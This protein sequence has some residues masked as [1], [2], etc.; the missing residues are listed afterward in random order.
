MTI[1][2]VVSAHDST[3]VVLSQVPLSNLGKLMSLI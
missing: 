2:S 1:L 3:R